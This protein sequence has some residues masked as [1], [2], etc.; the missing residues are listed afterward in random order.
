[1]TNLIISFYFWAYIVHALFCGDWYMVSWPQTRDVLLVASNMSY[2]QPLIT[3][4]LHVHCQQ[5][6]KP[7][8]FKP[9]EGH[10]IIMHGNAA[11][12]THPSIFSD[13]KVDNG[14]KSC[15]CIICS[16]M[17]ALNETVNGSIIFYEDCIDVF[18]QIYRI[19]WR[20]IQIFQ[21][22]LGIKHEYIVA[23]QDTSIYATR[24]V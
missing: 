6:N 2:C 11:A 15:Q 7:L 19:Y 13:I 18:E 16:Q 10:G 8:H 20:I 4:L 22:K 21:P 3:I 5:N 17:L 9:I 24:G 23:S 1:M 14:Q 12:Y